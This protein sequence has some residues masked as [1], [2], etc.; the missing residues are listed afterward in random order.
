MLWQIII[1][2]YMLLTLIICIPAST[3][4][5]NISGQDGDRFRYGVS[6]DLWM[7]SLI[8]FWPILVIIGFIA[9]IVGFKY[10]IR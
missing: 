2:L 7:I 5:R 10:P 6:R 9:T 3:I 4:L 8:L 1:I